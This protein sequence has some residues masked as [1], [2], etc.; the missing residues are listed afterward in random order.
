M[1][2]NFADIAIFHIAFFLSHCISFTIFGPLVKQ[3][4]AN[5][6]KS[7]GLIGLT[8]FYLVLFL[9][10]E[11]TISYLVPIALVYGIVN[12]MY[13]ISYHV[14][15]F[16]ITHT[17]NRSHFFGLER[18]LRILASILAPL[19]GG[20]LIVTDLLPYGYGNVFLLVSLFQIMAL[21][22]GII[23]IPHINSHGFHLKKTLSQIFKKPDLLKAFFSGA[24]SNFGYIRSLPEILN[25]LLFVILANEFIL[26]SWITFFSIISM[27]TVYIAG[28][29]LHTKKYKK[30]IMVSG[31]IL[32]TS[33]LTLIL[34][35]GFLTYVIFGSIKEIFGPIVGLI[36]RMYNTNLLHTL[37]GHEHHRVEFM[38][39]RE[40]FQVGIGGT[41][42]FVP[43]LFAQTLTIEILIPIIIIMAIAI[44]FSVLLIQHIKTDLSSI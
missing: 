34:F 39:L 8:I 25:I 28:K 11:Q 4:Q 26:G 17:K 13:W 12:G 15:N 38:V 20:F 41:I 37:E 42:A 5:I 36:R 22:T 7:I 14:Q 33:L 30:T 10:K 23:D 27:F 24:L 31:T 16:D 44:L 35:P 21:F 29:K 43:L 3:G 40:W 32:S 2:N 18:S 6:I 19:F 9:L 1:T